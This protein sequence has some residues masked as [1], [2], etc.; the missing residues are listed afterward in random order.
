MY[1]IKHLWSKITHNN[2]VRLF[3]DGLGWTGIRITPFYLTLEER[4]PTPPSISEDSAAFSSVI[5]GPEDMKII[6][7]IPLRTFTEEDLLERL[8]KGCMCV[9]IMCHK[10]LAA[11]SWAN[12][13]ECTFDGCRFALKSN[14]AYMFD[15][16]TLLQYRGRGLATVARYRVYAELGKLGRT[17]YYSI[18]DAFNKPSLRFKE[19]LGARKLWLGLLV[20]LFNRWKFT[21]KLKHYSETT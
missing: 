13:Q 12:L 4:P 5:L 18:S 7:A 14:E 2:P 19:K 16:F 9:G 21:L 15:A 8:N 6:A 11:F 10:N 20:K 17:R 1:Y 3:L